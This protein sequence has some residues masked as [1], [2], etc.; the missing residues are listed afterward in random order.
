MVSLKQIGLNVHTSVTID[1]IA[2][3]DLYNARVP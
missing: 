3:K 1:K 2:T